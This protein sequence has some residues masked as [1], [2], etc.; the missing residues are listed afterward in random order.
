MHSILFILNVIWNPLFFYFR[1]VFITLIIITFL[2]YMIGFTANKYKSEMRY[3][4]LLLLPY[5][6]WLIIATSLNA[7]IVI[8]N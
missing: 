5:F 1:W 3:Y 4:N 6:I 8:Y 7:Y 2:T